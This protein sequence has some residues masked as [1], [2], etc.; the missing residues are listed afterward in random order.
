QKDRINRALVSSP[1]HRANGN[2]LRS[3]RLVE[4]KLGRVKWVHEP[5]NSWALIRLGS[6]APS[7]CVING[8]L[9]TCIPVSIG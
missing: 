9:G 3:N 2:R 8:L 6:C 4:L 5:Q 7:E 1:F